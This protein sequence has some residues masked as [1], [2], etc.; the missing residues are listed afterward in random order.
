MIGGD[1]MSIATEIQRIQSAK[2]D[3]K[4]AIESKGVVVENSA[5][6]DTFASKVAEIETGGGTDGYYDFLWDVWQ[7]YGN[8]NN[9]SQAFYSWEN[10]AAILPKYLMQPTNAEY[11][12][13]RVKNGGDF[14]EQ[15]ANCEGSL[16]FS[17]CTRM[18]QC[19]NGSSFTRLGVID[20]SSAGGWT[21]QMFANMPNLITIDKIIDVGNN[22]Y[23]S[24]FQNTTELQNVTFEGAIGKALNMAS[25]SK[26]SDNSID[27]I[28]SHLSDLTNITAQILTL[29]EDVKAKLTTEQLETITSKNWTLA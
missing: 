27:N 13:Y 16:D 4:N 20:L 14:V 18:S 21:A 6:I 7:D 2:T 26:L 24:A 5:T 22:T 15:L 9:Y 17:K 3:L 25:C 29:H 10:G 8:R 23:T 1:N 28:I 11:M 19:F 12:F